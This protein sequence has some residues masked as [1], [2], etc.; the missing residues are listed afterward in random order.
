MFTNSFNTLKDAVEARGHM[1]DKGI[2]FIEGEHN[3][4][5][6]TY[7]ELYKQSLRF[8]HDLQSKGIQPQQEIVIQ[9]D[10]NKAF[11]IAFWACI[12]GGMIVIPISVG[13]NDEHRMK[14]F[15]IW[16]LLNNPYM[17][18]S[19]KYLNALLKVKDVNDNLDFSR[20]IRENT[21]FM[22]DTL[23]PNDGI[24]F[25]SKPS[26]IAFIQFSSGSTGDPKGVTLSHDNLIHNC[27][28]I[29]N[30]TQISEED[31][32]LCWVPLTHDMGLIGCH[33]TSLISG[34]NQYLIP[35]PLFIRQPL[36]WISKTNEYKAT[37]LSS[38]NFGYEYFLRFFKP[39]K[40]A[41]WELSHV[42]VIYNGAEPISTAICEAFLNTLSFCH[43]K[44]SALLTVYGL[45]EASVAVAFPSPS[46]EFVTLYLDRNH[47]NT[48]DGV[49]EVEKENLNAVSFVEVGKPIDYCEV[50]ICDEKGL[51]LGDQAIGQIHIR[52]RNV[53]TGYY[54]NQEATLKVITADGWVQTGDLGFYRN[55]QLVVTGREK[56]IIFINGM[57]IYPHDIERIA[58]EVE[59]IE[60]NRA[61]CCG[62][63]SPDGSKE[64]IIIFVV[65][66]KS[67]EN[68]VPIA[69]KLKSHLLRKGSWEV[70]EVIP[71]RKMPKTTSGKV[72]RY[73]LGEQFRKGE[74][75]EICSKLAELTH[76]AEALDVIPD[77][78]LLRQNGMEKKLHNIF[79]DLLRKKQIDRSDSFFDIGATS[80]QLAQLTETIERDLGI[81]LTVTDL[82]A[83]PTIADLSTY[84]LEQNE[85]EP[86]D[87]LKDYSQQSDYEKTNVQA[88]DVR[89]NDIAIIGMSMNLP[90][91]STS[92]QL[93]DNLAR[94]KDSI[95][96]YNSER[97]QDAKEYISLLNWK[98]SESEFVE[99][100]Y[101]DEI[102]KFDYSFFKLNPAE[103][104]LMD[105]NQRLFLASCW[106]TIEDAGYAGEKLHGHNVGV[107]VGY[108]KVG[109]DYERLVSSNSPI[110]LSNY[111]VGNLPSVLAGRIAYF[112]NLKGPAIT[113]DT[114]CSSS[115]VAVHLAC[116]AMQNEEC[117]MAI[118]GGIRTILLPTAIGLD[119]ESKDCKTR[120]F[121]SN[122]DGTGMGEGVASVLLK[123][124]SKALEDGDHIYAVVKGS[125]I[126]QDGATAG[127]TAP[128]PFSQTN[129]ID[130]AWKDAGITPDTL[131]FI[132]AH[133]TGTKLGD[134]VEIEGLTKAFARYTDRKQFCAIGSLKANIGHLFEAAGIASLIK[135]VLVLNKKQN[136][137]LVHFKSPNKHIRFETT[138]FYI[139]TKL[140]NLDESATPLRCGINAFGFSGTNA[141]IV[142]EQY[143]GP[144]GD[145]PVGS[146][147]PHIFT[148]SAKSDWSLRQL[149]LEYTN[150]LANHPTA[151]LDSICYTAS[152]GR[153]HLNHR[154]AIVSSSKEEL[155]HQLESLADSSKELTD[156]IYKG[157]HKPIINSDSEHAAGMVTESQLS[158]LTKKAD[159]LIS[160]Y[161]KDAWDAHGLGQI[162][163]LYVS[164]ANIKWK[165]L[166]T[167]QV[168]R[169]TP[170]PLYAFEKKRCWVKVEP[171]G[172]IKMDQTHSITKAIPTMVPLSDIS[173]ALKEIIGK[174]S[175]LAF[176]EIDEYAHFLEM[177]LDSIMLMQIR[178][179]IHQ[180][181]NIDIPM[182]DFFESIINMH[183]LCVFISENAPA[184]HEE[185]AVVY[186][187]LN[188]D[189][190]SS[191]KLV[192]PSCFSSD[193]GSSSSADSLTNVI[194]KQIELMNNQQQNFSQVLMQQLQVMGLQ[195]GTHHSQIENQAENRVDP[196][197]AVKPI[198]RA[199]SGNNKSDSKPF[200]PYQQILID[201]EDS[202]TRQQSEYLRN[203]ITQ[204]NKKTKTSKMVAD[205]TRFMHANNRNVSGF[206]GYWKELVYP[207]VAERS[208][209]ARMW[210]VDG[211][212]YIDLTMGF[213]V[214]LFGHNPDFI[215]DELENS[216]TPVLPPL[217]PMS[218]VAGE[219]ASLICELTGVERVA[220][221]N[222]GTEAV[223][224]ALR[225]ARATTRRNKVVIFSGSYHGTFDGVLGVANPDSD[226]LSTL[227]M[228]PGIAPNFVNDIMILNYNN[229]EA[230]VIIR[231]YAHELAAV[232]V[233]PV[234]SRRPDLQP[235]K[236]LKELRGITKQSGSALIFDE[237]ITGFRIGLGGA[238][239]YFKVDA[240]LVVYGKVVGGGMPIGIVCGKAEFMNSV[241]G[242]TW[243]FG[244]SSY[245]LQTATKTF[246]G[247][248][249]CTHPITMRVAAK[250]LRHLQSSGTQLFKDLNAKT[251][252][253]VNELNV[254]FKTSGVPIHMVN[255]GSLFRFVSY[256]DIELFFYHLI[257]KGI[258]IWEGRNCFLS[259]VHT[260]DDIE[261]IIRAVKDTV[262]D[263]RK[264]GFL[265]QQPTLP[266]GG[267][268]G[269]GAGVAASEEVSVNLSNEQKQLWL[270]SIIGS[271]ESAAA[272]QSILLKFTGSLE[273]ELMKEAMSVVVARHEALRTIIEPSGNNQIVKPHMEVNIEIV[274]F[275]NDG[276]EAGQ[277]K[278]TQW[279]E[280]DAGRPFILNSPSPLFR[281]SI[282]KL[283]A[284]TNMMVLTF[285]HIIA[286]GWSIAVFVTELEKTY[287]SLCEKR[288][289]DLPPSVPFRAYL[290]WEE[291]QQNSA[292]YGDAV[293]YWSNKFNQPLPVLQLPSQ[294]GQLRKKTFKSS[295]YT[296]VLDK[297]LTEK[298]KALS[299]KQQNSLFV[300]LLSGYK[301]FLHR[302][303][304]QRQI[305]VGIPTAGQ[306]QMGENCL[307]GNCVN[308]LPI[309]S[310]LEGRESFSNYMARLKVQ[311]RELD[312][313]R[314][315]SFAQLAE[316]IQHMPVINVLFNMDRPLNKLSF[317]GLDTEWVSY[318][319]Q[320]SYYD[321][322][323]NVTEINRE[324]SLDLDFNTDLI[325][326][327]VIQRWMDGF[328]HI[329]HAL[330]EESSLEIAQLSLLTPDE[331]SDLVGIWKQNR[332][333][334]QD[335]LSDRNLMG[336]RL[337]VEGFQILDPYME[338]A[339]I[340]TIGEVYLQHCEQF[341]PT[342]IL[343]M[344]TPE[345]CVE[346]VGKAQKITQIRG[347]SVNLYLLERLIA[348]HPT[349]SECIVIVVELE[350]NSIRGLA[351]YVVG[352]DGI[353]DTA[354]IKQSLVTLLPDYMVPTYVVGT[355]ILPLLAD[356]SVDLDS[357]PNLITDMDF[358]LPAN[359]TE[360][361]LIDI[362]RD[363]LNVRWIGLDD[364]FFS[365]GGNSLK[366]TIMLSK[367][368]KKIDKKI[369]IGQL[370]K[371]S[372]VRELS[373][374][375]R[376]EAREQFI[377]ITVVDQKEY[378]S[379]SPAQK[380]IYILEQMHEMN[381][382]HN[383]PGKLEIEGHLEVARL[384]EALVK[385][386]QRHEVFRTTFTIEK[387]EIV[388][389]L[390]DVDDIYLNVVEADRSGLN[391]VIQQSVKPFDLTKAPL[392]RAI[393]VK[394]SDQ[395]HVLLLDMHHII[396]D[397]YSMMLLMEELIALYE[398]RTLPDLNIQ[399][400]DYIV[401]KEENIQ[402]DNMI[403]QEQY[404]LNRFEGELPV[405]N[406]PSDYP[407]PQSLKTAG[408]RITY[409]ID[410]KLTERLS[411]L[412][413][414]T[415][416]TMFMLMLS[417]Y[418]ILLSKYTDQEDIIIGTA[419]S[420]R[421]HPDI[422]RSIGV[423]I[424]TVAIRN[425]PSINKKFREFLQEVKE[426]SLQAFE[427][428]AYPFERL[429][430]KLNLQ[431]DSSRNPIF[432]TMFVMQNMDI[433]EVISGQL[434]F[435]PTELNPGTSQYDMMMS[436][437][438]H[439]TYLELNLDYNTA[440]FKKST[441]NRL[442]SH[443]INVL[444]NI[445]GNEDI[446]I[447][448]IEM[449]SREERNQLLFDFN[450]TKHFYGEK[451]TVPEC[452]E[453]QVERTPDAV[454]L[455]FGPN[456]MSYKELN[457]KSN[458]LAHKLRE[459]GVKP[460]QLVGIMLNRSMDMMVAILGV[461][462]S[463]AAYLP[464]D[465][466][467]PVARVEYILN[468]AQVRILLMHPHLVGNISV[469]ETVPMI[470]D[471][472]LYTGS[473]ENLCLINKSDDLAYTIYTSGS[474]GNPK[475]V[476]I[477]HGA[478]YNLIEAMCEKI[479]F[480]QDKVILALT[481][482]SFDIFVTETLLPL[483]RGMKVVIADE[484]Q[485]LDP[486]E[487]N[488]LIVDHG[489]NM[490]QI[491]PSRLKM[492]LAG[493]TEETFLKPITEIMVGGEA[494]PI[495]L[496]HR[497]QRSPGLRIYNLYG[498]TETTVYSCGGELTEQDKV[499]IG[500]PIANT[501]IY[502]VDGQDQLHPIGVPG[503]L[504]ISGDGLAKGYWNNEQ[505]TEEK[506]VPCPF[507]PGKSMYRTGDLARWSEDGEI[508][509][510]GRMDF[511]VKIRGYRI[512][513][514]EIERAILKDRSVKEAVVMAKVDAT[515]NQYLIAYYV[516]EEHLPIEHL[517]KTL[518]RELP[519][520]MVPSY[521]LS[522][523]TMPLTPNGKID[524][525]SLPEPINTFNESEDYIAPRNS[526]ERQLSIIW[527][528]MLSLE[529]VGVHDNFFELGGHSLKATLLVSE[530]NKS[531]RINIPVLAIFQ[532]TTISSLAEFIS[533][534]D[535]GGYDAIPEAMDKE[536]YALSPSQQRLYLFQQINKLSTAYNMI[537]ALELDGVVDNVRLE[538]A[539]RNLIARHESLRTSFQIH[540]GKPVQI[541][542]EQFDFN[543]KHLDVLQGDQSL[544]SILN[545]LDEPFDLTQFPL[546]KVTLIQV[547]DEKHVL[548][549]NMH[550]MIADGTSIDIMMK[551]LNILYKG[552]LLPPLK[553]QFKDYAE[554]QQSLMSKGTYEDQK[555]Y[556]IEQ[557]QNDIPVLTLMTDYPRPRRQSFEGDHYVFN[558]DQRWTA[559]LQKIA[560]EAGTTLFMVLLS[561]YYI[562]LAKYSG[563]E[564][565][566]VG[567]PVVG[568]NHADVQDLIGMFV[569]TLALRNRPSRKKTFISFLN[570]VK[571]K[572][573]EAYD[574][575]QYPFEELVE[576]LKLKRDLSGNPL[577]NVMFNM[578]TS[579]NNKMEM[580]GIQ[581]QPYVLNHNIAKFDLSL[582][583]KEVS[584]D[585]RFEFEY[586]TKLFSRETVIRMAGHYSTI[587][588]SIMEKRSVPLETID[589]LSAKEREQILIDFNPAYAS[590][591][592]DKTIHQLFE[593]QVVMTPENVAV[594]FED[595]Q[596][597]YRQ[598]NER[599]NQLAGVLRNKG[600][601]TDELVGIMSDR[602]IEMIVSLLAVLKSGGAYLPIDPTFPEERI[603]YMLEESGCRF[604]LIQESLMDPS[605]YVGEQI[606]LNDSNLYT[607]D[608]SNLKS[609]TKPSDLAYVIFTSGSTG[610]PKGVMIEHLNVV[611]L[612]KHGGFPYNFGEQDVWTMFHSYCFDVSVWEMYG[613]L[614]NGSK[615]VVVPKGTTRDTRAFVELVNTH[616]VTVL[617]QTPTAFYQFIRETMEGSK[618]KNTLRY[619]IFAGEAL[620]PML[621]KEWKKR[622]TSTKLV[623]M[624]GITET[625]VHVTYKEIGEIETGM[626]V[627]NIGKPLRTLKSY[628]LNSEGNLVPIGVVGELY[629][630]GF[631]VGRGYLNNLQLT[632]DRY[633]DNPFETGT[634]MYRSGDL[635]KWL[636]DGDLEYL[637]R[638]DH[639]VKIRGYRIE[640]G[641][642]EKHLAEHN[643]IKEA[644]V[645]ARYDHTQTAYLCAYY[646]SDERIGVQ[647]LRQYL[648]GFLPDYM[649]PAQFVQM[650]VL[651]MNANGKVDRIK[652]PE[653]VL[654]T[655]TNFVKPENHIQESLIQVW[656]ETLGIS[657][658][659]IEHNFFEFGG[660][661]IK[662][663]QISSRLMSKY[664]LKMEIG[665][666]FQYPTIKALSK[667][668]TLST[669]VIDQGPVI[670]GVEL[671][672]IQRHLFEHE[673]KAVHHY[674]QSVM[675]YQ[676]DGIDESIV[677][678]SFEKILQHHDALRMTFTHEDQTVTQFNHDISHFA[679]DLKVFHYTEERDPS[680]AIEREA[681]NLQASIDIEQGPMFKLA[682]FRTRKGDHLLL[683]IHHLVI[684]GVS[685]RFIIEDFST[686]Y[687]KLSEGEKVVLPLKTDSFQTWS[688][689]LKSY[690]VSAKLQ[691]ELPYWKSF[692]GAQV[693]PLPKDHTPATL[694]ALR[695]TEQMELDFAYTERLL[696]GIH[697]AY[698]TEINDILLAALGM[699]VR[700]WCG[701]DRILI[702]LEGH[703]REGVIEQVDISR[704]VGWFTSISPF[705]L[706]V[707]DITDLS[708]VVKSTKD[709]L[710][711]VPN[712]GIGY[713]ILKYLT[714]AGG[715]IDD[716]IIPNL[717]PEILFNYLGQFESKTGTDE[718]IVSDISSGKEIGP[719]IDSGYT[720]ETNGM[721]MEE[722]FIMVFQ[723][724]PQLYDTGTICDLTE[725]YKR[726]LEKLIDHCSEKEA[727]EFTST[728]YHY[729]KL[730]TEQ[731]SKIANLF[732]AI[733]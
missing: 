23:S 3:E 221:Y 345:G 414:D 489:V 599:A 573:V 552:Q 548:C 284:D 722:R 601:Q 575:Q 567:T 678:Q 383:I 146:G 561:A 618:F 400:K 627:S 663:I 630:A 391:L 351:A 259:T 147:E 720:I 693:S 293:T 423:F 485:Q 724:N 60:V 154:V 200:I 416:T 274:D 265:P 100:G 287:T 421:N 201:Q 401:W 328:V 554:W 540:D 479:Q 574:N 107:Y 386:M 366:A 633:V 405:L 255:F 461:L 558:L 191:S 179:E 340:G 61:A 209:G 448:D 709:N 427:N 224:V 600:V 377:P 583:A 236:F 369:Q 360:Q 127:V 213:G 305:V 281:V 323:L 78:I 487:L 358:E 651:P 275:S 99:G 336:T 582:A 679:V 457:E 302:L 620:N 155:L 41:L 318:P 515:G 470:F 77:E 164:G 725:A 555:R 258:Y 27:S 525:K 117:E 66:K 268:P 621:L 233:E 516:T 619:V 463:G 376:D 286:D 195:A 277:A 549:M 553:I 254:Y 6:I 730:S 37:L 136:P 182:N 419:I 428:Q 247:G 500:R 25:E 122:S 686:A 262:E 157:V 55:G 389:K 5:T 356:G 22:P 547:S 624:Y 641:E 591:P 63:K 113:V 560:N 312:A 541:V 93:W 467:Y 108:S 359:E 171:K 590:Y 437:E 581:V 681:N 452:F 719:A 456:Q 723:Y 623:N 190:S 524:K 535:S 339:I 626:N 338:P 20:E 92:E 707:A 496:L 245:P 370:F 166:Y 645:M 71:I 104:S 498:P 280:E 662:A 634:K 708:N 189:K 546:L 215:L 372:T 168:V 348:Q 382:V 14:V 91:A 65:T 120:T 43:L 67:I 324:L 656:E 355:D 313:Y 251:N 451:R 138:P 687:K 499:T 530:I 276:E 684:D 453:E 90:G 242:G 418:N 664:E 680:S 264:G 249:F 481:T 220:F 373:R 52:G 579:D 303:T 632:E 212:E 343:A 703:G 577:F 666:L 408:E 186:Q 253:L 69:A 616:S 145:L 75:I 98:K 646:I 289:N 316:S 596:L 125:A 658:L 269:K 206:R 649:I 18:T 143:I 731:L 673:W 568:R 385:M 118:A 628:I 270:A 441:I 597:T 193:E 326:H 86:K 677:R 273:V 407:R 566:V 585:I 594:I 331:H 30:S 445:T 203:F 670:G 482:I 257:Q 126:N 409:R 474:T 650:D 158:I 570:E 237:V 379:A 271:S 569:N 175:G 144:D 308:I 608:S 511:Q 578:E 374:Y 705:M 551:E 388:Q 142:L 151:S 296:T 135:A 198:L 89:E 148:L 279:L 604:L 73:K 410:E 185:E 631:G 698:G 660:D 543:I 196:V 346:V 638:I 337:L 367:V 501:Q 411:K 733:T 717:Y 106:H 613:A 282:L 11:V 156:G 35:T 425:Y 454:A 325:Q 439:D 309:L 495:Q 54:N 450:R 56:D 615:L 140:T 396:S 353:V 335:Q 239:E 24:V 519:E 466:D 131:T 532:H 415:K 306:A 531:F 161:N 234:Q 527:Q 241:D 395:E 288:V 509:Y 387:G 38:P 4:T 593:E 444:C 8:L 469:D 643:S 101:L 588:Q 333:R 272:N 278:L 702:D 493:D 692:E 635:A 642:I 639:Q 595:Q 297:K 610:K 29:V 688:E 79:T 556:W 216:V 580:D 80:I 420:G 285:H 715:N 542:H 394:L 217:G 165:N 605:L 492:L 690:A 564:D 347:Y 522:L 183:T 197:L 181:F 361:A 300:T 712:K 10:D 150:Y 94:G 315:Y 528:E 84:L 691:S 32:Y 422:E 587:L 76:A 49:V 517:R 647:N 64:Q 115:L 603:R 48:G 26:D 502:I 576:Q 210:D 248:T 184:Q 62:V 235:E 447:A 180:S 240:D 426:S 349:V 129:V 458:Q 672:P 598:L 611:Q 211:N 592:Q 174:V 87:A 34:I 132:E 520:Y 243:R 443:Y 392:F 163:Q 433:R 625:T 473:Q 435:S 697:H 586:C 371:Y 350:P 246:V 397:G 584:G 229:P 70:A 665:D 44:R 655:Q 12:L 721:I 19:E 219:V 299:I 9:I 412:G 538:Q 362:W 480:V 726:N 640:L 462:K 116:K 188:E 354:E 114:A 295:R 39:E 648:S 602:S 317:S 332:D 572:C 344:S 438:D 227:P 357:L 529:R 124:L 137:A 637:G 404:W 7:K 381:L 514:Q 695:V 465:P 327:E 534:T 172:E 562:L 674:N 364:D 536:Y 40:A 375:I 704:T 173:S 617:C 490:L 477:S 352:K 202:F 230:L 58:E 119:M 682:L 320:Y 33:L 50:R 169:K 187:T 384:T 204:Y 565:I 533:G 365:L 159:E 526:C 669:R 130:A 505:L 149:V 160:Q 491:T 31:S 557:F 152:T 42:R 430:E 675:L 83:Y 475:G 85:I 711:R 424:N 671:A 468:D 429:V 550:H 508:E 178:K 74:F 571:E 88:A 512:E 301:L 398:G 484:S 105:P 192:N 652:L 15:K 507:L 110:A 170:L 659:G 436:I 494:L 486:L 612:I 304:G 455:V 218:D 714:A 226:T 267:G 446:V 208:S 260:S 713:G 261:T 559:E 53:T 97:K 417:A 307:I 440:L 518:L 205:D 153:A 28:G 685:W 434:K 472:S 17:V 606:N 231:E 728:D 729:N 506:F 109:Y 329:L 111:V 68:F 13:N 176:E 668:I 609:I 319:A 162:C 72:Q 390:I 330:S 250:V 298:L 607:G 133:G 134:P 334:I 460:G 51:T 614:L 699:A 513:L 291:N 431:R 413:E 214:N 341:Q 57:N 432:D 676:K 716:P 589:I 95:K 223:M 342:G 167:K 488:R 442:I 696:K 476:M 225:L 1:D 46:E 256:G 653:P 689:R 102:D 483:L 81:S 478:T 380:R 464:I 706:E 657:A 244:D 314:N 121:D 661:S 199:T 537:G 402:E 263:L 321:L 368:L 139:D 510:L 294:T 232:L 290:E 403:G 563:Q 141:H 82:F 16:G 222:S 311:I 399:Y 59:G 128:N 406:L 667:Y 228:A 636:P 363:I 504:C 123:P 539:F 322:F 654:D 544:E 207:I 292:G 283:L 45:A 523:E 177:G 310:E 545:E 644:F 727:R 459:S 694:D 471:E 378:Y 701:L 710:R 252:D 103:A 732:K 700:E 2:T 47:L 503:E 497:L 238:Q 112:L 718:F 36:L 266:Q 449:I 21:M 683:V 629:V 521:F 194:T 96:D 393:L 622:Y